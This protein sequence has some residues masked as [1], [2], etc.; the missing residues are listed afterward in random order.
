[1]Y[2]RH[3]SRKASNLCGVITTAIL[4][5]EVWF[6]VQRSSWFSIHLILSAHR[7]GRKHKCFPVSSRC[8]LLAW[9]SADPEVGRA[10]HPGALPASPQ[11]KDKSAVL[12]LSR[13]W[14]RTEKQ[15]R[16]APACR[17]VAQPRLFM[18]L[19][20]TPCGECL[21]YPLHSSPET[22]RPRENTW[23]PVL[24]AQLFLAIQGFEINSVM[25]PAAES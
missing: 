6:W 1:M 3:C 24:V 5:Q 9:L 13:I 12:S 23:I 2:P 10:P 17:G 20:P 7:V 11:P 21:C 15:A 14:A 16:K 18:S 19:V 8:Y 25:S 22:V 4:C